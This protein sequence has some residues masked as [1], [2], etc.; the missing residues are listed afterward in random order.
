MDQLR[1]LE[2]LEANK[3][4]DFV[5]RIMNAKDFPSLPNRDGSTSTIDMMFSQLNGKFY[6]YPSVVYDE[7]E[8]ARLGP[9]TAF[10]RAMRM[11]D[12]IE[13][14]TLQEA[15]EFTKEYTKL[16][17]FYKDD[18]DGTMTGGKPPSIWKN[19]NTGPG[20]ISGDSM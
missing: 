18:N 5:N 2:I 15:Y 13:F 10:G 7:G 14:P 6:V 17:R 4:K 20:T 1:I 8:M 9:D 11:G 12:Y 3:D 16:D 19:L